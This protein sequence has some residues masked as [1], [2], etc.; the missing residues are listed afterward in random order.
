MRL[1]ICSILT[2]FVLVASLLSCSSI[3]ENY[4]GTATGAG[5]GGATGALAGAALGRSTGSTVLGGLMGALVGGAVGHYAYD[6]KRSGAETAQKYNYQPSSGTVLRMEEAS[7][8]PQT[9]SPGGTVNLTMTYAVMTPSADSQVN[10]TETRVIKV[11]DQV[12]GQPQVNVDRKGGTYTSSVPIT[13]PSTAQKGT[14][15]VSETIQAG[16]AT[17]TKQATF[18]VS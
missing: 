10:V 2:A 15:T 8:T 7:A 16:N 9:V 4:R 13:L 6:M 3:P 12:V 18:N 14:Y 5:V 11:N 17:D 1:R